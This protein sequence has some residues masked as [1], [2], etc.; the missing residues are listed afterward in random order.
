MESLIVIALRAVANNIINDKH[1]F[2]LYGVDILID[3]YLKPWL[4]E[5]NAS[6]SLSTTTEEDRMLKL[7]LMHDTFNIVEQKQR[8]NV[9]NA[10]A[11]VAQMAA[12]ACAQADKAA[13]AALESNDGSGARGDAA[14][15]ARGH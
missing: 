9:A 12:A 5:V 13:A 3:A 11:T 7:R 10:G 8:F 15:L 14:R 2:E 4:L 1:C 6:P